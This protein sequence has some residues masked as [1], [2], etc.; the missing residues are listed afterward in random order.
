MAIQHY[1]VLSMSSPN[2]TSGLH[3]DYTLS[4]NGKPEGHGDTYSTDYLTDVL[5]STPEMMEVLK[6]YYCT[7]LFLLKEHL[8][9]SF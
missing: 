6:I 3:Y 1:V 7:V 9:L 8:F 2:G 5:V 4:A